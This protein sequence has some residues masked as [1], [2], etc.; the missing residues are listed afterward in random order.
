M[1]FGLVFVVSTTWAGLYAGQLTP[2]EES[3]PVQPIAFSHAKHAGELK[4]ECLY[5][6]GPAERG[7]A[8]TVP[9]VSVCMGCHE[10]VKVGST[11]G[12]EQEIAKIRD[13][14]NRG[15]PI[16]WV[17]IH[18]L[19]EHVQFKHSKHVHAGIACQTCHGQVEEMKR[20]WEV[21]YRMGRSGTAWQTI[22]PGAGLRPE[23]QKR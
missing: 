23:E 19:P 2:E 11:E 17:R 22:P 8:A 4:I 7:P 18:N 20:V 12:S 15:E 21:G 3:G 9:A 16:P 13:Y 5:C 1:G 10:H 6:H 14:Y